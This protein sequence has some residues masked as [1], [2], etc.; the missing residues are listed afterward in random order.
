MSEANPDASKNKTLSFSHFL[1]SKNCF[2]FP[3]VFDPGSEL[4]TPRT[5]THE[6][7]RQNQKISLNLKCQKD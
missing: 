6:L 1:V 5:S 7:K 3:R 4:C 2:E